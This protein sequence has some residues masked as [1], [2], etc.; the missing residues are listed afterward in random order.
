MVNLGT[1]CQLLETMSSFQCMGSWN[2][3]WS[4]IPIIQSGLFSFLCPTLKEQ[5]EPFFFFFKQAMLIRNCKNIY[6]QTHLVE[7]CHELQPGKSVCFKVFLMYLSKYSW[8][9]C[10]SR[11]PKCINT[12]SDVAFFQDKIFI[13]LFIFTLSSKLK[14]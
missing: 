13:Y 3:N 14:K 8:C 5:C 10:L 2:S 12:A 11:M 9:R 1:L 6:F 4:F 7:K